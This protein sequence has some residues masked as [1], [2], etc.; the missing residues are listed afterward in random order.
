MKSGFWIDQIHA[1]LDEDKGICRVVVADTKGSS[2]RSAGAEMF[3]TCDQI[4]QSIG[5]GQLEFEAISIARNQ[6]KKA[7]KTGFYRHWQSF[8][9]GPN[10]GQC[11]GGHVTLLFEV[12]LPQIKAELPDA[13]Q[14]RQ[15]GC[16]H[17][18]DATKICSAAELP[19]TIASQ[20]KQTGSLFTPACRPVHALYLYGAGHVG[21]Q[22]MA[23]TALLELERCWID[24][25][26]ARFPEQT[27]SDI[28]IIPAKNMAI[29]AR[30]APQ[31]AIHIVMS[32]AHHLDEEIVHAVLQ[33]DNFY[34]LGLIG[35][36]TKAQRF[37]KA[38]LKRGIREEQLAKLICPI[39]LP[40]I[41]DKSP[42]HVGLA[43]AGQIAVW[44]EQSYG[45]PLETS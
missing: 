23:A 27:S 21:R 34:R 17:H 1:S 3:V 29:I 38:L 16:V 43:V 22:V 31:H 15:K 8:A 4:W 33:Q 32:Y 2:P 41:Q 30:H 24:T 14:V 36:R 9:L 42:G 13:E 12:F 39:G 44:L 19:V 35:S 45:Q 25:E 28:Q 26:K 11:C 7:E 10:L 6:F 18:K 20:D 40:D 37:K 5:G